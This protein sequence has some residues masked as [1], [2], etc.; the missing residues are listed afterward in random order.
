MPRNSA[1]D[2]LL[3]ILL[4]ETKENVMSEETKS[5]KK[6]WISFRVKPAEYDQIHKHFKTTTHRKLS[7]YARKVLLNKPVVIRYRNQSTDEFLTAMIP[8]KNELNSIGKNFNQAVKKLNAF[9][10]FSEIKNW[11]IIFESDRKIMLEKMEEIKAK[12]NQ[13]YERWS[14]E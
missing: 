6:S 10:Q 11:L 13:L 7:E 14:Q 12:I 1:E 3:Q 8:L 4:F 2:K 5:K 9:S